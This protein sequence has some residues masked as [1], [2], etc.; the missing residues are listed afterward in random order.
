MDDG[1]GMEI[2]YPDLE[3]GELDAIEAE[4]RRRADRG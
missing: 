2:G 4:D 3:P 1:N